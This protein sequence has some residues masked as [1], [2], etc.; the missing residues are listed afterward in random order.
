MKQTQLTAVNI[1]G[2]EGNAVVLKVFRFI[3]FS[4]AAN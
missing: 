3:T 2:S 1:G 4:A